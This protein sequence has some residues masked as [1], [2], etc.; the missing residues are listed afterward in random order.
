MAGRAL[1]VQIESLPA[2][3]VNQFSFELLSNSRYSVHSG[4]SDSLPRQVLANVLWAM[5]RVPRLGEYRQFYVAVR[6]NVYRYD[7]G[8]NT[9]T[10]HKPGDHRYLPSAAFEVGVA[11][12]RH[13]EAG[14]CIQAGLIAGTAFC[15][16]AGPGAV[17]CPM[18]WATDHAN[19]EWDPEHEVL[20]VN[21]YGLAT[22]DGFDTTLVAVSSDL[23]LPDPH[24]TASDSFEIVM[25]GLR[26]DSAF[27]SM[28]LTLETVSQLLWAGYGPTP[29]RAYNGKR[30]LTVPSAVAGYYLTGMVYLVRDEGVDRY[31][32]RE[33]DGDMNTADHRL[34]RVVTGDRRDDLRAASEA[35]PS[36]APVYIV[37]CVEDTSSYRSMQEVGFAGFQFLAQARAMGLAGFPTVALTE[38]ERVDI[39]AALALPAGEHPVLVFS[40]GELATGVAEQDEPALVEITRGKPVIRRGDGLTVEFLLRR[41]GTVRAEV[42][43]MLGRPVRKL[44]KQLLTP[45]YHTVEWDGRDQ[46]GNIADKGSYVIGIFVPGSVAQHKVSVF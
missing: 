24:T 36:T 16:S 28:P 46:D 38:P 19:S 21:V 30:G 41:P 23:S 10:V 32:N 13:E 6:D 7:T 4:M 35:I 8:S 15:D 9:L 14:F 27:S 3:T 33:P 37:V 11:V 34:E 2:P 20:E 26:R 25:M 45:G 42:Y 31:R 44:Y 29:H 39:A 43:D 1:G 5:G 22:F 12:E 18:K 40:V 17:G